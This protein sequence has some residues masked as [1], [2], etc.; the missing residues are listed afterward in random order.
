ME[1]FR[2]LFSMVP[3]SARVFLHVRSKSLCHMRGARV[4][5]RGYTQPLRKGVP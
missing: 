5:V 2:V 4:L 3:E 1:C